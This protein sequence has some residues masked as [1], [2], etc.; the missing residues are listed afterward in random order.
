MNNAR[1]GHEPASWDEALT[2]LEDFLLAYPSNRA[3]PDL[4]TI[5]QRARLPKRF[6]RDDERAQKIL[7]EAIASR[8]LSSLEQVTR[9]RTEVELL[10]FETEVLSQRLQQDTQDRDEHRRTAERLHGVRRRLRE[11]RRDL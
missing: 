8:P 10:T 6:L 9:V 7:R 5:R 2:R 3:L 1:Y 4:V 11:I